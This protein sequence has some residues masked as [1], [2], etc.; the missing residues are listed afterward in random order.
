V[1]YSQNI[2]VVG[3]TLF[4]NENAGVYFLKESQN[5]I[6]AG[7]TMYENIKGV[8]YGSSSAGGRVVDNTVFDNHDAGIAIEGEANDAVV[9]RNRVVN[10]RKAQLLV[11]ES[12]YRSDDNCF[13]NGGPD[14]FVADFFPRSNDRYK[15][16]AQYQQ[17]QRQDV[18]SR[19][20][21]CGALPKKVDVRKLHAET[22]AYPERARKILNASQ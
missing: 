21:S 20:G 6:V 9:L 12:E 11:L 13:D 17:G 14:Q 19:Q 5:G 3:N 4:R 15:T 22:K 18:S 8:R 7:N 1:Y 16:L 2:T 10:N